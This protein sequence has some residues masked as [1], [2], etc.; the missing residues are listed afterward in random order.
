MYIGEKYA[1]HFRLDPYALKPFVPKEKKGSYVVGKSGSCNGKASAALE[2]VKET[3]VD[4][5]FSLGV[6][7]GMGLM[8]VARLH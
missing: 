1:K 5:K 6:L 3:I 2:V 4:V 7:F 8:L